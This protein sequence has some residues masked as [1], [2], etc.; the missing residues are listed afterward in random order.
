MCYRSSVLD[1]YW[2]A[3]DNQHVCYQTPSLIATLNGVLHVAAS[4]VA[5][6]KYTFTLPCH[7]LVIGV[8]PTRLPFLTLG[9]V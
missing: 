1:G 9:P 6:D 5:Q 7:L 2:P 8:P 3:E 4:A